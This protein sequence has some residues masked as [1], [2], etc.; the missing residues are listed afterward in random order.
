MSEPERIVE[1]SH[2][3][4][5]LAD[6]KISSI[7]AINREAKYL[8]LNAL[9]ES[10]RAGVAGQGF[11]IVA[12][13]FKAISERIS[14]ISSELTNELATAIRQLTEVGDQM[15]GQMREQRGQRL[16]DLALNMIEIMDR[17]LYERSCDVRWWA[18]DS[19]V[20][21]ALTDPSPDLAAYASQRLGVILDSYTVY[22]D[23]WI[24][25]ANGRV[26]ANGRPE[27]FR[28]AVGSNVA[29]ER[30]FKDAMKTTAGT[31]FAV[32]DVSR[33]DKLGHQ[34][35]TYA[36]AVRAGGAENGQAIGA[37]GI[38]FD[39]QPQAA[40]VVKGVGLDS[41]EWART[42]CLL[43][44]ANHRVLAASDDVGLLQEQVVLSAKNSKHGFH[45]THDGSILAY[46]QTP[47]YETYKGLGWYGVVLQKPVAAAKAK[48]L[49][50]KR[51]VA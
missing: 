48:P 12:Q 3:L 22:L 42:R 40:A 8:S 10:G 34:V 31:Q 11:T 47:G 43:I 37:L 2:A 30:W 24:A 26:I 21:D 15:I 20:V 5:R 41:D 51:A 27:Q 16:A 45:V 29:H 32:M 13:E 28:H 44:D 23:L 9:V 17:N 49:A 18:T 46:A 33:S 38:F 4:G 1:L 14:A 6:Q 50:G 19:A 7:N 39:W 25:D 36:T 35:A